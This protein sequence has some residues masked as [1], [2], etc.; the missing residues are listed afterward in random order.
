MVRIRSL[1]E[2][3][4]NQQSQTLKDDDGEDWVA[5]IASGIFSYLLLHRK[6][7]PTRLSHFNIIFIM[8]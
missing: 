2:N 1:E 4:K 7:S 8:I 6:I 3:Y 5:P